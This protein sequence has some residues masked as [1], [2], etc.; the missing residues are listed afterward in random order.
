[1]KLAITVVL[2][3]ALGAGAALAAGAGSTCPS[4]RKPVC[5]LGADGVRANVANA[6]LAELHGG[7][8]LH[9][10]DCAAP[11]KEPAM[12]NMLYMPVCA[13]DPAT[14]AQKTYP[15]L[16]HAELANATVLH[17]NACAGKKTGG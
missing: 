14:K 16:C 1:M 9:D 13:T 17:D 12:C 8:V 5:A 4:V 15:N 3:A 7:N 10:G 2:A 11:G 6:C